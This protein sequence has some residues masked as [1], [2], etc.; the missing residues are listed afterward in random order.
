MRPKYQV[1]TCK[2]VVPGNIKLP[3]AF[4]GP[5][6]SA[7]TEAILAADVPIIACFSGWAGELTK[8]EATCLARGKR[9]E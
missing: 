7:A 4:D 1:W 2:I 8:A 3:P 9:D 6:R 5:P